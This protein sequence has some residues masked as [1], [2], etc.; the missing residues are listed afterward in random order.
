MAV[1]PG[2]TLSDFMPL[3]SKSQVRLAAEMAFTLIELLVVIAIIAI[4]AALLLPALSRAKSKAQQ[5]SCVNIA[6]R[7]RRRFFIV[8]PTRGTSSGKRTLG[9]INAPT[10]M[11][12]MATVI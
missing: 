12:S 7:V 6:T 3:K 8:Q 2:I 5:I 9:T 1:K 10:A 4:L 11:R